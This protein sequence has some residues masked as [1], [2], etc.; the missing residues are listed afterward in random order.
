MAHV[1]RIFRPPS[2]ADSLL[3]QVSIGCSH[4]RCAYCAMYD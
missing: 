2:E 1:G 4:N 3:L